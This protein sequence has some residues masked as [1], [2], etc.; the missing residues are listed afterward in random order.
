MQMT[1]PLTARTPRAFTPPTLARKHDEAQQAWAKSEAKSRGPK[2]EQPVFMIAVPTL[3]ERETIGQIMY[4]LGVYPTSRET[5]RNATL[6]AILEHNG[7]TAEEDAAWLEGH[8]QQN[9]LYED[10][11]ELWQQQE[12][13]RLIDEWQNPKSKREAFPMP[14]PMNSVRDRIKAKNMVDAVV[15]R[16]RTVRRLLAAQTRYGR[17]YEI[18]SMRVH[19]RGW[20]GV[21]TQ[22]EAVSDQYLPEIV[23]E[24]SIEKLREEIGLVAWRE[25]WASIDGMYALGAEEV[26][27]SDSPSENESTSDG[28]KQGEEKTDSGTSNGTAEEH[29]SSSQ[30]TPDQESG[31]TTE[32]S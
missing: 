20:Q 8:W 7:E 12:N 27:N 3:S 25:I 1:I 32:A 24:E 28:S 26:G 10:Q 15:A 19:L 29:K 9:E 17:I 16:D 14:E 13:Q 6:E 31:Q 18:M 21:K 2:P 11:L 30:P 22:R 23:T 4:E 5:V